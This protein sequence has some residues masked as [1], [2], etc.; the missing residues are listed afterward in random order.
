MYTGLFG[1]VAPHASGLTAVQA[2]VARRAAQ[3]GERVRTIDV[4]AHRSSLTL[5]DQVVFP[6]GETDLVVVG[7]EV[8]ETDREFV[9]TLPWKALEAV[10]DEL[11]A[12]DTRCG[13]GP[14]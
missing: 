9:R 1:D 4:P 3:A 11:R 2:W 14:V 13:P 5:A 10:S 8:A 12:A 6:D 7:D